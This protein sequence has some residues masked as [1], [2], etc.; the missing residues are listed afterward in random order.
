MLLLLLIMYYIFV[1]LM[2]NLPSYTIKT[3]T[4]EHQ[5]NE[6]HKL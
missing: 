5:E 6:K 1:Y 2:G 4:Y 3:N